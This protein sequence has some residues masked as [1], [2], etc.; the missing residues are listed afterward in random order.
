MANSLILQ[1]QDYY[2]R[3]GGRNYVT[4]HYLGVSDDGTLKEVSGSG[5]K[6]LSAVKDGASMSSY[7]RLQSKYLI[8]DLPS[9]ITSGVCQ[10]ELNAGYN[11]V[12]INVHIMDED[13]IVCDDVCMMT[14]RDGSTTLPIITG[15][16]SPTSDVSVSWVEKP[17]DNPR[18]GWWSSGTTNSAY[19]KDYDLNLNNWYYNDD[20]I[21][22]DGTNLSPYEKVWKAVVSRGGVSKTVTFIQEVYGNLGAEVVYTTPV[23]VPTKLDVYK[24][25]YMEL[26]MSNFGNMSLE[27]VESVD[28]VISDIKIIDLQYLKGNRYYAVI[29]IKDD[30]VLSEGYHSV[31]MLLRN[32]VSRESVTVDTSFKVAVP[33]SDE[34]QI[35]D[36]GISEELVFEFDDHVGNPTEWV[37]FSLSVSQS[38]YGAKTEP[39]NFYEGLPD[40]VYFN[41]AD[42]WMLNMYVKTAQM[43]EDE[44][45]FPLYFYVDGVRYKSPVDVILRKR[46]KVRIHENDWLKRNTKDIYCVSRKSIPLGSKQYVVVDYT[47]KDSAPAVS[48]CRC[49]RHFGSAY[50]ATEVDVVVEGNTVTKAWEVTIPANETDLTISGLFFAIGTGSDTSEMPSNEIQYITTNND[51]YVNF[52]YKVTENQ[53]EYFN[54][55]YHAGTELT[56]EKPDDVLI[57]ITG[58]DDMGDGRMLMQGT[59]LVKIENNESFVT[60]TVSDGTVTTVKYIVVVSAEIPLTV[61]MPKEVTEE[62]AVEFTANYNT[63]K[64]LSFTHSDKVHMEVV[65]ETDNPDGST[66]ATCTLFVDWDNE[67]SVITVEVNDGSTVV[68]KQINVKGHHIPMTTNIPDEVLEETQLDIQINYTTG[69]ALVVSGIP[70]DVDMY[71]ISD[72]ENGDGSS[73]AVYYFYVYEEYEDATVDI[74]ISDG[75]ETITETVNIIANEKPDIP[76]AAPTISINRYADLNFPQEGGTKYITITY[77]NT[78]IVN[79]NTPY[80]PAYGVTI[81]DETKTAIGNKVEIYYAVT[82]SSTTTE[83]DI[84]L[85]FSCVGNDGSSCTETFTGVQSG[86]ENASGISLTPESET[87]PATGGYFENAIKA[88]FSN[89]DGN[90]STNV[91]VYNVDSSGRYVELTGHS[92][93]WLKC[94]LNS[95]GGDTTRTEYYDIS[96]KANSSTEPS[97][98][99]IRFTY[100][101][102]SGTTQSKEFIVILEAA[103][104]EPD[105]FEPQVQ[106]YVTQLKFKVDGSNAVQYIDYFNVMYQDFSGGTINAPISDVGWF[107]IVRSEQQ[108]SDSDGILMRYYYEVDPNELTVARMGEV[109]C[110]GNVNGIR[111]SATISLTQARVE[112][113]DDDDDPDTDTEDIP[114]I[115]G[116]YIGQIWKDVEFDFGSQSPASYTIYMGDELIYA[117]KSYRR[118]GESGNKILVNKIV[119]D[120]LI[121]PQLDLESVGWFVNTKEFTLRNADGSKI[122][123]TY[124][125]VNDWSYSDDFRTGN[126]SHHILNKQRAV[127]GQMFPFSIFGA[128]EQVA[129]EYG[130]RYMDGHTDAYGKPVEDWWSTEYI[131][132]GVSTDFFTVARR[133]AK[134]ID[135]V[136]VGDDTY[137]PEE[138]EAIPY[139]LYYINPWGGFDWFPIT[140]NVVIKDSL[141]QYKYTKNYNNTSLDFGNRKYLTSIDRKY[142]VNTGWMTQ[143]ESE[144][145]WYLLE[146][147]VVYLHDIKNDKIYPV[148]ISD[149]EIEHKKRNA[150]QKLINYKFT[151]QL[152]HNRK[153]L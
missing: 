2:V 10:I 52:P 55:V 16:D 65:E 137:Y 60:V 45:T 14:A 142:E 145:M 103:D 74:T 140:G 128:G 19:L 93:A 89:T 146:S 63:G 105:E 84:P 35:W 127:R 123:H 106:P 26:E 53:P 17:S 115:E 24:P 54:A 90:H 86:E 87:I 67:E 75:V 150:T 129:I 96:C 38:G 51:F 153:R 118:P 78:S 43:I 139:V 22:T 100:T 111:Y 64:S 13:F 132:N 15:D 110:S 109:I 49:L 134:Y 62:T 41:G 5:A 81:A 77:T 97:T 8:S 42:A 3:V 117:G 23:V 50:Q 39:D 133:D 94:F 36:E 141:T 99:V 66:T 119:Q 1:Q 58:I 104:G 68:R 33:A 46:S 126:L 131:T 59:I 149:T 32:T 130:V 83:R 91:R 108:N 34:Y 92:E 56:F 102:V 136:W 80:S 29:G 125:F 12:V 27:S 112:V 31:R 28:G 71:K 152:S 25:V 47:G 73:T 6:I 101:D 122:S 40:F 88:V 69:N 18:V 57:N 48:E 61:D 9:D 7:F 20:S 72:V 79:I 85:I 76:M 107:R 138:K 70:E 44:Y 113:P 82:V 144:R 11:S 37:N 124:F 121:Q 21:A 151:C 95:Y 116:K 148:L 30:G 114:V 143:Q 4:L 147:N 120:Y 135:S 98:G